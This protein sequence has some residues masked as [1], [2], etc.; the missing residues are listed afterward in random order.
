LQPRNFSVSPWVGC[1]CTAPSPLSSFNL[2]HLAPPVHPAVGKLRPEST[3]P[4]PPLLH[5]CRLRPRRLPS[6]CEPHS[7]TETVV[8]RG[9]RYSISISSDADPCI[10]YSA[11]LR[12]R[13]PLRPP[14]NRI[15]VTPWSVGLILHKS[16]EGS[17][18]A[19]ASWV[20]K[21]CSFNEVSHLRPSETDC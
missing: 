7:V 2:L 21:A 13:T 1:H 12:P 16:L 18:L 19:W 6:D 10:R 4:A 15:P 20:T 9:D 17:V 11:L 3:S 14:P 8:D 5:A